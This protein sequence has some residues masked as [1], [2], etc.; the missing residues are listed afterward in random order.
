MVQTTCALR[1]W[2]HAPKMEVPCA[3]TAPSRA[4]HCASQPHTLF[5]CVIIIWME[6]VA[7][8]FDTGSGHGMLLVEWKNGRVTRITTFWPCRCGGEGVWAG[9]RADGRSGGDQVDRAGWQ[10]GRVSGY[11]QRYAPER[12]GSPTG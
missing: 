2:R 5:I 8:G 7:V 3:L 6:I 1:W 12:P 10:A 11:P 4:P 9:V